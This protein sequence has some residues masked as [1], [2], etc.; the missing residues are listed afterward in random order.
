MDTVDPVVLSQNHYVYIRVTTDSP[1][2]NPLITLNHRIASGSS[3]DPATKVNLQLIQL[4]DHQDLVLSS[5]H[6]DLFILFGH[7]KSGNQVRDHL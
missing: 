6:Q 3:I 1:I 7:Y 2:V 5:C 4:L